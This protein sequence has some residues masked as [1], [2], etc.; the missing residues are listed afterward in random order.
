M[1]ARWPRRLR[2]PARTRVLRVPS[3]TCSRPPPARGCSRPGR[4]AR[5]RRA[6]RPESRPTAVRSCAASWR[7]SPRSATSGTVAPASR[8]RSRR[9]PGPDDVPHPVDRPSA[10]QHQQPA[11]HRAPHLVERV[12]VQPDEEVEL[13]DDLRRVLGR[14]DGRGD[15]RGAPGRGSLVDLVEGRLVWRRTRTINGRRQA[16]RDVLPTWVTD[17]DL[18]WGCRPAP[19]PDPPRWRIHVS[20]GVNESCPPDRYA[21]E[22]KTVE[23]V[24]IQVHPN[25]EVPGG[26]ARGAPRPVVVGGDWDGD[27]RGDWS[28][29]G[30]PPPPRPGSRRAP[31]SS[32][33]V[34]S[35]ERISKL[36]PF[37]L[38][39]RSPPRDPAPG[40]WSGACAS[41]ARTA[42]G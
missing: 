31:A 39:S 1:A 8:R 10:G 22:S 26:R 20:R 21:I 13:L 15:D 2:T 32:S 42:R 24:T 33:S 34:S 11:Q 35:R 28:G 38:S 4:S 9:G 7:A 36:T 37:G 12:G 18:R 14:A 41:T 25:T 19:E 5:P 29:A 6:G 40:R 27:R 23:Q 30:S 17:A 16:C 3:G